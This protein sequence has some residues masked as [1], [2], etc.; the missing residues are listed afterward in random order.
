MLGRG[1]LK[2]PFETHREFSS[3]CETRPERPYVGRIS[4]IYERA[5]FSGRKVSQTHVEDARKQVTLIQECEP[6]KE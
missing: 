6:N 1:V 3:K 4:S 5:V 2:M